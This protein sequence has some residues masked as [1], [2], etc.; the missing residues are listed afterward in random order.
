MRRATFISIFALFTGNH[1]GFKMF[2]FA[3]VSTPF[4][5]I[6]EKIRRSNII[7]GDPGADSGSEGKSKRAMKKSAKKV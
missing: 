4:K 6:G 1:S 2:G 7:L 3:F 5:D